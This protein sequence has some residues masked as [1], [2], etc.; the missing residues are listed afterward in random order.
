MSTLHAGLRALVRGSYSATGTRLDLA[1]VD[2]E[3]LRMTRSRTVEPKVW[4][5]SPLPARAR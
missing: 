1:L 3:P 5:T 2:V 4:Y